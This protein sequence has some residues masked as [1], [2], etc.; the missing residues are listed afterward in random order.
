MPDGSTPPLIPTVKDDGTIRHIPSS[1]STFTLTQV[2]NGF[3]PA[4]WHPGDHGPMPDIVAHGKKPNVMACALCHY[5][6]GK[7]RPENAGISD[8]PVVYF[9]QQMNDFKSGARTSAEPRKTNAIRMEGFAKDMNDDEIKAAAEYFATIPWTP[10]IKVV[11]SETVPKFRITAGLFLKLEG[12]EREPLG[13]RVIELADMARQIYDIQHGFRKGP[14]AQ[15]MQK[16]VENLTSDDIVAI[17][18]YVASLNP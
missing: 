17:I 13:N 2:R 11:E 6:N 9:I 18:A 8:L 12:N 16:A 1:D 15:L 4:D 14:S 3:D 5:S 7:G 10:W